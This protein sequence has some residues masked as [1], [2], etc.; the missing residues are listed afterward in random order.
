MSALRLSVD[1]G[2]SPSH[3]QHTS[4]SVDDPDSAHCGIA[5]LEVIL[6]GISDRITRRMRSAD[7][8]GRTIPLRLRFDDF[9]SA[10][11]S[12]SPLTA[13]RPMIDE[14]G[15]TLLGASVGNLENESTVQM[16][17]PF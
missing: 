6:R 4:H 10:T 17:L 3:C 13:A 14:R 16:A 9:A 5:E 15:F 7:R 12:H 1:F 2:K 8:V 11:R